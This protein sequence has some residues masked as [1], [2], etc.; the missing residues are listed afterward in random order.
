MTMHSAMIPLLSHEMLAAAV[1]LVCYFCT[2]V[3]VL[4]TVLLAPRG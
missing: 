2:A 1:Q 3:G 4:L